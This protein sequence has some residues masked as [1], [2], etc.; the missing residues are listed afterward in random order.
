M[1]FYELQGLCR[2]ASRDWQKRNIDNYAPMA[3]YGTPAAAQ[4][5]HELLDMVRDSMQTAAFWKGEVGIARGDRTIQIEIYANFFASDDQGPDQQRR[6]TLTVEDPEKLCQGLSP[7]FVINGKG[8][9][10]GS[11]SGCGSPLRK[12]GDSY[13]F[14]WETFNDE[15]LSPVMSALLIPVPGARAT[16]LEYLDSQ[17]GQWVAEAGFHWSPSSYTEL[18]AARDR[19]MKKVDPR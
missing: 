8:M 12:K 11:I 15:M 18:E 14:S 13:Y 7:M 3:E 10:T 5:R 2:E 4:A 1:K 19:H 6:A 17:T 16:S 9:P